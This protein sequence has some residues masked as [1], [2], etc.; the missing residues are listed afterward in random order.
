M[1][2]RK[3]TSLILALCSTLLWILLG[4]W[5]GQW[6]VVILVLVTQ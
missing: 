3:R 4:G 2:L 6:P 5:A 1:F